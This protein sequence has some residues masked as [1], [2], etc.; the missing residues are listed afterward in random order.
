MFRI[1]TWPIR[2]VLLGALCVVAYRKGWRKP[3]TPP[4]ADLRYVGPGGQRGP[5]MEV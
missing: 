3:G 5:L 4:Y 2:I 1:L